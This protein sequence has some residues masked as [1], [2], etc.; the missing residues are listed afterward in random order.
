VIKRAAYAMMKL[1]Q[2]LIARLTGCWLFVMWMWLKLEWSS[3]PGGPANNDPNPRHFI[4]W[5]P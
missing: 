2:D 5:Q 3:F 1:L 4:S